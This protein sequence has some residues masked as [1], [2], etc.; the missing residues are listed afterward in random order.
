M[1]A[2]SPVAPLD[3]DHRESTTAQGDAPP[4][5]RPGRGGDDTASVSPIDWGRRSGDE[6][7]TVVGILLCRRHLHVE[8]IKPSQGDDGLDVI[9]R[10]DDC[11]TIWQVKKYA[12]QPTSDQKS[13]I[14]KSFERALAFASREDVT[15]K[16]WYLVMPASPT[17]PSLKW[18]RE[19]TDGHGFGCTWLGEDFLD[20]LAAEFQDVI[21]YYFHDG[22]ERVATALAQFASVT[23]IKIADEGGEVQP[24]DVV[25]PILNAH[26]LMNQLD[27]HFPGTDEST[28][29]P[30][31]VRKV[32]N[33]ARSRALD[34][35][36]SRA[37]AASSCRPART[38]SSRVAPR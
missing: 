8:R 25:G 29:S 17:P 37:F 10:G 12:D 36:S 6:V 22:K 21:D 13:K 38:L 5:V 4:G 30:R 14:K 23:G 7:E 28:T 26:D 31:T 35:I 9:L 11:W 20:G 15:I 24:T 34:R 3:K 18:F 27:P 2:G 32:L 19:L 1:R 33:G 16:H